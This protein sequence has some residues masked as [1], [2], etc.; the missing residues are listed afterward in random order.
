MIEGKHIPKGKY[1]FFTIPSKEKWTVILN[2]QW[3][4]HLA[5][6]YNPKDDILRFEVKSETLGSPSEEL[7]YKVES[8]NNMATISMAWADVKISFQ[9]KNH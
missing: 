7:T 1:G 2:K 9:V 8:E 4:M 5:D 6:D 3:D